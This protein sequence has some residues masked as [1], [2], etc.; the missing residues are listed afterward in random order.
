MSTRS[1][2]VQALG[3]ILTAPDGSSGKPK[4][5]MEA[6][7]ERLDDRER[8]FLMEIVYGVLRYK[9]YLDWILE[10]FLDKPSSL[11]QDT[12]NNLR[13]AVYQIRFMRVP[14]WAAVNESVNIEKGRRNR[15]NQAGLVNAVLRNYLRLGKDMGL[16]DEK[17]AISYI[18]ITTSHPS[19]LISRWI[20]RLGR[21]E[22]LKLAQANNQI[23]LLTLRI[24]GDREA[25]M[26]TLEESGI[27]AQETKF[28][29]AGIIL[30]RCRKGAEANNILGNKGMGLAEMAKAAEC[31]RIAPQQIPLDVLSYVI[32]D[33]AAQLV[34]YLLDPSPGERVLDAC[35]AP[36]GKTTHIARLMKDKGQ[37]IALDVVPERVKRLKENVARLRLQCVTVVR[38]DIKKSA[39][40]GM[41]DKVLLDAPCSSIGVI[42]RNPDV[43]YRHTEQDLG[44]FR[45][46]Q[47]G[48]MDRAASLLKLGGSMVYSV[49]ST[50]PEEGEDVVKSFLQSHADFSIIQG[51]YSFLDHFSYSNEVGH[52]FYRTWPH[53]DGPAYAMDGFFA[54]RLVREQI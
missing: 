38:G 33:E 9:D 14:E 4:E 15:K 20:A 31:C 51:T 18:S 37:V 28:S 35:A 52:V 26:K 7:S 45:S 47:I 6:L 53:R 27:E 21:V 3:K 48:L 46:I 2:A 25:A 24:D 8:S 41:F 19:W 40:S 5:V 30:K 12:I 17:E 44:R 54:V 29:P 11:S 16:P 43:K 34:T 22:A 50:E 36:G 42:R 1:V 32:Q 23:P 49:C 10:K 13:I 39:V